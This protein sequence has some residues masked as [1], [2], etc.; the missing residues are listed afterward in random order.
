MS[1]EDP[2]LSSIDNTSAAD[3]FDSAVEQHLGFASETV[4]GIEVAQAETPD[5]GRT[6]R[7]PAQTPVQTAAAV[8]PTEV[9][10]NTENVVTLP[11]GIELDNLEFEVEG[12]N[13]VLI[14]ADGTEIVVIGGAANIPT[15]VIGDVELPQ[16][17]LFA[18]LEGSNI[19]VAAGPDG[20]FTAQGT[21]DASRNLVDNPIDAAPEDFALA[22]LLEDTSF[23]D[24]LRTGTIE[25]ADGDT[26]PTFDPDVIIG[27]VDEDYII[28][29]NQD[30][31]ANGGSSISGSLGINWGADDAN[32]L[33][34][35]G[36]NATR[37]RGVGF[38][39]ETLD[40]L[41]SQGLTSDGISLVYAL[42]ANGTIL[43]A[44]KDNG[45]GGPGEQVFVATVSDA[46]NGSYTFQLIGNLDHQ[47]GLSE[48][49]TTIQ[50]PF[51]AQ[52]S[53]GSQASSTFSIVVNDDSPVI[54]TP[55]NGSVNEDDLT[56]YYGEEQYAKLVSEPEAD[57]KI[58]S[59]N[60][61]AEGSLAIR[62]GADNDLKNETLDKNGQPTGDD[63]IGRTVS[64]TGLDTSSTSEEIAAAIPGLAGLSSDGFPL[65]YRIEHTV[66][67]DGKWNGGYQ[68]I[69]FKTFFDGPYEVALRVA[70]EGQPDIK[71]PFPVE[72][73]TIFVITLDPTSTNGSYT[74]ELIGNL[75]HFAP[76]NTGPDVIV[77]PEPELPG[78]V[79]TA[80][81]IELEGPSGHGKPVDFLD[82]E[83]PFTATDSDGDSVD[84]RFT[85]RVEDDEP[86]L[87]G[88]AIAL[89]VDED[90]ILTLNPFGQGSNGTSPNDGDGDGSFTG[91]SW[92][93]GPGPAT[94]SG[95]LGGVVDFGADNAN[96]RFSLIDEAAVRAELT[97]LG[98]T[99]KGGELSFDVVGNTLYAFVNAG[100]PGVEYNA[101]PDRLVFSLEVN[102]WGGFK[103]ELHDQLDHDKPAFGR[104][105]NTDL[106]DV[107]VDQDVNAIDFG[108]IIKASDFDGDS[109]LLTGKLS[110]TI[111]DDV[112]TLVKGAVE[113]RTVDEDDIRNS[114]ST[115][116]S[117]NDGNAD[118][119][120][121][122]SP[123]SNE[124]GPAFISGSLAGLV[125]G[126]A[127]D[128]IK[129]EFIDET[130]LRQT[131]SG[132]K[133]SSNGETLSFD[134]KGNVLW[135]F[136]NVGG[137][138]GVSYDPE[139]GDR[140]V[141]KLT[142]N[143]DGSY[144]FEL[145]DQLDHDAGAGQNT[146]LLGS[147]ANA[148]DFGSV[149]KVTDFDGDS[150]TIGKAFS[151]EI[152]D[153]VPELVKGAVEH[154]TV[155]EDDIRNSQSMGTSPNDGNADGSY[156]GS[157][158]NNQ[159]GPA[160][161][162]G[163]LA[164]LVK[165]GADDTIKFE[166][167]DET[168]L[169]QTLSGLKLSSNGETLSF[170]LQGNVLWGFANVGGPSGVSYDPENGDRP[171]FKL[172][173]NQDGSYTFELIDQLDHD[174]GAGQN[175]GLLGSTAD[176][177]DFGSVIKVTDRD[178]DSITIGKAFSIE[179]RDDVPELSG[180]K[181][182]RLVDE[183][184]IDTLQSLGTSPKD[185]EADGSW[186]GGPGQ[187]GKGGA[188]IDGSLANLIK[189]GAD[190][191]VK[192]SFID[193]DDA[194]EALEKLGLKSQGQELSYDI[195]D[196][197]LYAFDNAGSQQGESFDKGDR[198]VFTL[199]L[200]QD[201]S[202][203]FELVD[204]LDHDLGKG[205]NTDLQD[206]LVRGDVEAIDFG[207]I[208]K[209]TDH[210]GDS[211]VLKDAFSITI[212]DDVPVLSG[213][214]EDRIVD[215]DDISTI[216][217]AIPG[218]S[219]GT[220]PNDGNADGS[221][222]Q[223]PS[224]NQAGPAFISGSLAGLVKGGADD[225]VQFSFISESAIRSMLSGLGLSS[226]GATLSFDLK[227]DGTLYAFDNAGPH[228]DDN[229]SSGS[230]RLVFS[231]K[232]NGDGSYEFRLFDQ[233]DHDS[234]FDD[235]GDGQG[236]ADENFDLQDGS[237]KSDVTAINFGKLITATDYDGDSVS[238]D[239]AFSIK[240]RD[241]IPEAVA[242]NT[243]ATLVVDETSGQQNDDLGSS[244]SLFNGVAN[245]GTDPKMAAQF[246]QQANFVA[247]D[248][249]G[250]ADDDVKVDWALKLNGSNGMDSGLKTTD[251]RSIMLFLEGDLI[252]GRYDGPD[253]YSSVSSS[254]PA[255]FAL[256]LSDNGTLS[257]VQYVS[258]KHD[259]PADHDENNDAADGDLSTALQTLAGK[260]NA[261][262]T[263]TDFDGDKAVSE[264][265]VGDRIQFEDDGPVASGAAVVKTADEDDLYNAQSQGTSPDGDSELAPLGLGLAATVRGSVGAVVAFGADGAAAGGGFLLAANAAATM[266]SFGLESKGGELS[267]QVFGNSILAYVNG[268]KTAAF[269]SIFDR[270]V[271]SLELDPQTGNFVYRQY[272]Q[273]DHVDGNGENTA[274]Q[275]ASGPLAGIDFGAIID[276]KDGDGDIVNLTGKLT[277]NVVDDIPEVAI[278]TDRTVTIDETDYKQNDDTTSQGMAGLFA[279]VTNVG[280]DSDMLQSPIYAQDDVIDTAFVTGTDENVTKSL[281]LQID[282]AASGVQ[283]TSGQ[284]IVLFLENGL[285]VGR[286]GGAEGKAAFAITIDSDG[287]VSIAQYMSL[288]HPNTGSA[289]DGIDLSGK[290]SAVFSVKDFDGDVVTK[291]VSIGNKIVFEDDAPVANFS[292]T[293][294]VTE[295]GTTA[296]SFLTQSAT[297]T[298]SFDAGADGAKV[299]NIAYRFGSTILEMS[300]GNSDPQ[301]FPALTSGGQPVIVT[302]STDGLTVTGTVTADGVVKP[303]FT[304]V[305]TNA[306]TGGY[307]FTQT[308]PIDHPDRN[309]AGQSDSLRMV[310]DF[311]VTDG[312]GD[313]STN[314]V[315]VDIRDDGPVASY[316]GRVTLTEDADAATGAFI[317]SSANGQFL[318][319]AG[320]DGAKVTSIAYGLNGNVINDPDQPEGTPFT[321]IPLTSGGQPII[322]GNVAGDPLKIE[323]K[324]ADGTV[325]F[326]VEV[327]NP[328]TGAYT[329]TQLGPIDHPEANVTGADDPL[330]MK[331]NFTVTDGDGD[332][333]SNSIQ[334]DILD[335]APVA[336]YSGRVTL[337]EDADAA[338]GAFIQS[339]ANGQ[340]L[341]DAGADGA[342]VTSIAYGLNGNVINDPDQ[343]AGTPFTTIPL[344]SGGQPIIVG[345]VDGDPLKIEG[346]V[347][348]KVIFRVEVTNPVTGA[349]T[350]TQLG[351]IDHPE[352]NET[353]AAD[354]LRMKVNF[355]V[356][357]GDG[358]T[359][360]NSIQIDI[361]DDAPILVS[362]PTTGLSL[363]EDDLIL[364]NDETT[365]KEA[366]SATGNLNISL[367]ADGGSIAL[368]APAAEWNSTNKTLTANDGSWKVTLN[369]DGTYKFELLGNTLAHG[370]GDNGENTFSVEV[371]Y[372]ATD[373]DQDVLSGSF[374][375]EIVD[376]IPVAVGESATVR[377]SAPGVGGNLILAF[378]VS[379]SMNAD[380]ITDGIYESRLDVA[381]KAALNLLDRSDAT[382]VLIVTFNNGASSTEWLSKEAAEKYIEDNIPQETGG[383]NYDRA[384][385]AITENARPGSTVYFFSDG[386]VS[387]PSALNN[388]EK[389]AWEAFVTT[390]G[391]TSYAV[392]VGS[393][394]NDND[395][396]LG[397]VAHPG[398]AILITKADD[399]A[400]L[401]TMTPAPAV[402]TSASGNVLT[403]DSFGADGGHIQSITVNGV[404]HIWDGSEANEVLNVT[405]A[406]GGSLM[407][408]FKTGAWT[409][410]APAQVVSNTPE[411]F[412]Y[413]LVDG[414]GDT[415]MANL[416]VNIQAVNDAPENVVPS[417]LTAAEDIELSITNVSVSDVDAG[418]GELTV[419]LEVKKGTLTLASEDDLVVSYNGSG[420]VTLTGSL[421]AI[422]A[423]LLG[424][425]YKGDLNF[426]GSDELKITTTDNGN[427]GFGG[428]KTDVDTVAITVTPVNDAPVLSPEMR[429]IE[430][431][432]GGSGKYLFSNV[433]VSDVDNP[434]NFAGGSIEIS[435]GDTAV[436][437]D[438]IFGDS[439]VRMSGNN[440]QIWSGGLFTG[441]WVTIGTLASGG[442]GQTSI[443]INLT[444]GATEDR[445]EFFLETIAYKSTSDNPTDADRT[446]TVTFSD[447]GNTGAGGSLSDTST[448]TVT[449]NPVNDAPEAS[450]DRIITNA[451][452]GTQFSVAN[453]A[454]LHND[455]D[456]DSDN[457]SV[458][459]IGNR[460]GLNAWSGTDGVTVVDT[461]WEDGWF[462]YRASDGDKQ[463]DSV[464]VEV[465]QDTTGSLNGTSGNDILVGVA[466]PVGQVTTIKF[467]SSYDVG[468]VVKITIDGKAFS[469]TVAAGSTS[470]NSV[471]S[472]LLATTA[473]VG[474]Q[475][476]QQLLD[477]K[478]IDD[479]WSS[480]KLTATW[481]G[482]PGAKNAFVVA[483]T[484]DNSNDVGTKWHYEADFS[485]SISWFESSGSIKIK[486][487]SDWYS[488]NANNAGV[489]ND[490]QRF[491]KTA[492]A[493]AA[494]LRDQGFDVTYN[495]STNS[496]L[497][498]T[499]VETTIDGEYSPKSNKFWVD[500]EVDLVQSGSSASNQANPLVDTIHDASD[501]GVTM[502]GLGGD[503]ILIGS[504]AGDILNGD[505]GNDILFGGL[506]L[507][508]MTGGTGADTFVFDETAFDDIDVTDVI[509]D[510][511]LA[512]GDMLDVS[513]LLDSLLGEEATAAQRLAVIDTRVEG[514]NTFVTVGTGSEAQDIAVLN[515]VHDVKILFDDKHASTIVHD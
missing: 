30:D 289:D 243:N 427:T 192:F 38:T 143:Q 248:I 267:Y 164:S 177:I 33:G 48:N 147:T 514:G 455:T 150:I 241:D 488:E 462:T 270:P 92:S 264:I 199:T 1:I 263:V 44:Y 203:S 104:D 348:D 157:P 333:S 403:N 317:Q 392:G 463:S 458:T 34:N 68:L 295:N 214:K 80:A 244:L 389:A 512:Q 96:T 437:G 304:L 132:L 107:V 506:G 117:P 288:K 5:A 59:D 383:T 13:L 297:G 91:D 385:A 496:F 372:T 326:R 370:F 254:D 356:T 344:T 123:S 115:G 173:L 511:S 345:N 57:A 513:A 260:I 316:S 399:A 515:G 67:A 166:F 484:V 388:D 58:S 151:I 174:A 86:V 453:W 230:D 416:V 352:A 441:N 7:L 50:F 196:G 152:R 459:S 421:T 245:K 181:E 481:S 474:G 321:T 271:F 37:D 211:V 357:D 112:P 180:A 325:I 390:N 106:Q 178:G 35:T 19:N 54:G 249:D 312:D 144:S 15:F 341:F 365:P 358:D 268:G 190:D 137:P 195:R 486:I 331:V 165:G 364:G 391:M 479:S 322:V 154:R 301:S 478:G 262:L 83:I 422:N 485:N 493:L 9:T 469:H 56:H 138:S 379:A 187:N 311:I 42:S 194:R 375:I 476:L 213:V 168:D 247:A 97:K 424:M 470:A 255:A 483:A 320:A 120:Y 450:G 186:T 229:Y 17:A 100:G 359:S 175:T 163:S 172:T 43:T 179:I 343:P 216:G 3:D 74:F 167:I 440:V 374:T 429:N 508:T 362:A 127:D 314:A 448:I 242:R 114:Q 131:L 252:V 198:L 339:S 142:L 306:Q 418:N 89:T 227:S 75:D 281:T 363:N 221:Y 398:E 225:P 273:L 413:T 226:K 376:D 233:L 11:A 442:F 102:S 324:L 188:F 310:F 53:D 94:V 18:A 202:Y 283:T 415:T 446:V 201:G 122:G 434:A 265:A 471:Y 381:K 39:Q 212:K 423:A 282:D 300:E 318:F 12:A 63:P 305:V 426:N 84:G 498:K 298:L 360:S 368:S 307:T 382:H 52:D 110:V 159:P 191:T 378:D 467:A 396:D 366:L 435:L 183:D 258:I 286:V 207:S 148:I 70:D 217:N 71:L 79:Q 23:G 10:P 337:T 246:A 105:Q 350:V 236:I 291:S 431:T 457:L 108:N 315:Q 14:L 133:L 231:L 436:A 111:R 222:T 395:D 387:G 502:N 482:E 335:D 329:V 428:A 116:T 16:V 8:I 425:K 411:T 438:Q 90:D 149:I 141:F 240:V 500:A 507:D 139:N 466:K 369:S 40:S 161:I 274:L 78:E 347:G 405:T 69:A 77:S 342:K 169:R 417:S 420:N 371:T 156:T 410:N 219:L 456:V 367:G 499:A 99:S 397:D 128:T 253:N 82:L 209:A 489:A 158:S 472:A 25:G 129:F 73:E 433:N 501:G 176:A 328:V 494:D 238:L 49:N 32:V 64:F 353:G 361:L 491:D 251:G 155:D 292:G 121:T 81:L 6:D 269:D 87:V 451:G 477:D 404:T 256:H 205:E 28:E 250:G 377:E 61:A 24:E 480:S 430:F 296:G 88:D 452:V 261:V 313:T 414:D 447:G 130:V 504:D 454:L 445:V 31:G 309:E 509:T 72:G 60:P 351:P 393:N 287:D 193:E 136:A 510:Y 93:N 334:I 406:L 21:P 319:D 487:G 232:L 189:G 184:D 220:S 439:D 473:V 208:I 55:E 218:E 113:H 497:I 380:A 65:S 285:V 394:L 449:V 336:R 302:T 299:T 327:T 402:P 355:T 266:T 160:F 95:Y 276:A 277:I 29:G 293:V 400:L 109:V 495:T 237:S 505:D 36:L 294:I 330:R 460:I 223:S 384:I 135:G 475:T 26:A 46:E 503:D 170:D 332:T 228:T 278:W 224:N 373:G 354:P 290:I 125:K 468:D 346:K 124:P 51:T 239:G 412:T 171:V 210:D 323:G 303:V 206:G 408:N 47:T 349:Y 185:G 308:A 119:S 340:F 66:G 27:G 101:G 272:D 145:I 386:N 204:Q 409:Y 98:L 182:N 464:W 41:A 407:F 20:T 419:K 284:D 234:P 279:S 76:G 4:E 45:E 401:A 275:S 162:S 444:S 461:G 140:P 443:K 62:W 85:V 235:K 280:S 134:L 490:A 338:T 465:Q 432:E 257:L 200:K 492:E 118:G 126:G 153:D 146:G 22:D 259:D 2:R 215:E 103:F 197:V